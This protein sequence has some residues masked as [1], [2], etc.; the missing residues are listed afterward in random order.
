MSAVKKT[1]KKEGDKPKS[2]KSEVKKSS[3]KASGESETSSATEKKVES[4]DLA[5]SK[6][7]KMKTGSKVQ[8]VPDEGHFLPDEIKDDLLPEQL[9]HVEHLIRR[10]QVEPTVFDGSDGGRGKTYCNIAAAKFLKLRPFVVCPIAVLDH[11]VDVAEIFGVEL[12]GVVNYE[13]VKNGKWYPNFAVEDPDERFKVRK[14]CKYISVKGSGTSKVYKWMLPKDGILIFD[15]A[16]W[17]KNKGTQ[18]FKMLAAAKEAENKKVIVSA[19]LTDDVKKFHVFGLV[20]DFYSN[21]RAAN[22]WLRSNKDNLHRLIFPKKGSRIRTSEVPNLPG[23]KITAE[24][25]ELDEDTQKKINESFIEIQRALEELKDKEA[26]DTNPLTEILRARQRIE[27]LMTPLF[28]ELIKK[29]LA[30]GKRTAMFVNFEETLQ[31]LAKTFKTTSIVHGGKAKKQTRLERKKVI[32]DFMDNTTPLIILNLRCGGVGL[33]LHDIHST[34]KEKFE[35]ASI[36]SP[37]FSAIDLIQALC[38]CYRANSKT[39]V[40]QTIVCV[41]GTI[42]EFIAHRLNEKIAFTTKLNDG[43]IK[44]FNI[45]GLKE[46]AREETFEFKR[47]PSGAKKA[48]SPKTVV[49]E[50]SK[51][52]VQ[53]KEKEAAASETPSLRAQ[54]DPDKG[55]PSPRSMAGKAAMKRLAK[56]EK[57]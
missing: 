44:F 43:D 27:Y 21:L 38:R 23:N 45:Q 19:T 30:A 40:E 53:E 33:S 20:L 46:L 2:V 55:R 18:N 35:R 25:F 6:D 5:K 16:H 41:K 42:L 4:K 49:R 12:L 8:K 51:K 29:R 34:E 17:C 14:E 37:S 52:E 1:S 10:L 57:S 11:W 54:P 48:D 47:T 15:E 7:I 28:V 32:A 36:I 56:A 3:K 39:P 24:C 31:S 22:S 13:T 26:H 50:E 9:A